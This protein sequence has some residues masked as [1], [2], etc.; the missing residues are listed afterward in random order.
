M[1]ETKLVAPYEKLLKLEKQLP[2]GSKAIISMEIDENY[3]NVRAVFRGQAGE[4]L[5]KKVLKAAQKIISKRRVVTVS[6]KKRIV[7]TQ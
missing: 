4:Y 3:E 7:I 2:H 1:K 6:V 5:T